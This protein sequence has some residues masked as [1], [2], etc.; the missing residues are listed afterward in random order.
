MEHD[1]VHDDGCGGQIAL[2]H[3]AVAPAVAPVPR[4]ETSHR[5]P[6][7]NAHVR[8]SLVLDVLL[9]VVEKPPRLLRVMSE[10]SFSGGAVFLK[11]TT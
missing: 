8:T 1:A 4:S 2:G 10:S 7:N 11:K 9:H 5:V 6:K 3:G